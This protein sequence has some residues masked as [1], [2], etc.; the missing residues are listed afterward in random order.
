MEGRIEIRMNT[1]LVS[2]TFVRLQHSMGKFPEQQ[3]VSQGDGKAER[4]PPTQSLEAAL[5]KNL[6][7]TVVMAS[8]PSAH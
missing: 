8:P 4:A 7:L 6:S 5:P 2:S 3:G 1:R